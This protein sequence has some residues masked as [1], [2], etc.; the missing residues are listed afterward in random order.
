MERIL[1]WQIRHLNN[2]LHMRRITLN[3]SVLS[4]VRLTDTLPFIQRTTLT[5]FEWVGVHSEGC[6]VGFV[7]CRLTQA[8]ATRGHTGAASSR[9]AAGP[10]GPAQGS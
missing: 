10:G 4:H 6:C 3:L 8:V 2:G 5:V 1:Q 9:L 7:P